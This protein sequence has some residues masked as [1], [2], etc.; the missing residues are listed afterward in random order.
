MKPVA[1]W[2]AGGGR[3]SLFEPPNDQRRSDHK[4]YDPRNTSK[5]ISQFGFPDSGFITHLAATCISLCEYFLLLLGQP[6][7]IPSPP[8][9]TSEAP[10]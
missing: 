1:V 6:Y 8:I 9:W 3:R 4:D 2:L 7:E 5:F 10:Y